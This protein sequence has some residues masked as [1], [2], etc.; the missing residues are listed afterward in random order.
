M[1]YKKKIQKNINNIDHFQN[2]SNKD[3]HIE[4]M[5][6]SDLNDDHNNSDGESKMMKSVNFGKFSNYFST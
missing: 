6:K 1:S 5:R 3:E 2:R 4:S